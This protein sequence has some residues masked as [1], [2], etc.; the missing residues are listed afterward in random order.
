M[1]NVKRIETVPIVHNKTPP[2]NVFIWMACIL[3]QTS[4]MVVGISLNE[5]L[6]PGQLHGGSIFSQL[7]NRDKIPCFYQAKVRIIVCLC[8]YIT[9]KQPSIKIFRGPFWCRS[10]NYN[11]PIQGESCTLLAPFWKTKPCTVD[12]KLSALSPLSFNTTN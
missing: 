6:A 3:Q 1:T 2:R 5:S 9:V 7:L 11:D 4:I 12:H 8:L 10:L